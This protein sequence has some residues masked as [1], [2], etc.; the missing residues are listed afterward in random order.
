MNVEEV[1]KNVV[2]ATERGRAETVFGEARTVGRATIIPVARVVVN[3]GFGGGHGTPPG[4]RAPESAAVPQCS[5]GGG[6]GRVTVKPVAYLLVRDDSVVT[7][8]VLDWNQ[9]VRVAGVVLGLAVLF[10]GWL[11][12]RRVG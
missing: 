12:I 2:G 8:P 1:A 7:R 5:G 4:A 9:L 3:Y 6:G 11:A 10:I